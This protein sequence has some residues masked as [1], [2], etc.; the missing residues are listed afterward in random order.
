MLAALD[1]LRIRHFRPPA[2]DVDGELV[3]FCV[4]NI[5]VGNVFSFSAGLAP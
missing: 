1:G 5:Y 2:Q 3:P 4:E